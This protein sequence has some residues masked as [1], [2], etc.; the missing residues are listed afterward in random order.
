MPGSDGPKKKPEAPGDGTVRDILG[1]LENNPDPEARRLTRTLLK[2]HFRMVQ[3]E[4]ELVRRRREASG[5]EERDEI[6]R[7]IEERLGARITRADDGEED[8]EK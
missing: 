8:A 2:D 5:P 7:M 3:D 6:D 1:Y 4:I